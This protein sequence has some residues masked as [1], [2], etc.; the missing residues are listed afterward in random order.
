MAPSG[1]RWQMFVIEDADR[2]NDKAADALLKS[3][4]EPPPRTVWLLCAPTVEDVLP[5]IRSRCRTM[6][7]RT[8]PPDAVA[9]HLVARD[10]VTEAVASYAARASQ[11]HIGRARALALDEPTR[12]R[13]REVLRIPSQLLDLGSCMTCASQPGRRGHRGGRAAGGRAGCRRRWPTSRPPTARGAGRARRPGT[14]P[15]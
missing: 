1:R 15:R 14:P 4:E 9:A 11:G 5:T 12:N 6:V 8:P 13:R 7:L 2:L 10:G 3:I